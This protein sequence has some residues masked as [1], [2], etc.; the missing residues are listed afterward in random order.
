MSQQLQNAEDNWMARAWMSKVTWH[1]SGYYVLKTEDTKDVQVRLFLTEKLLSELEFSVYTQLVNATRF[2]GAKLVCLTPDAHQG[3]G[4]PVGSVLLTDADTGAIAMGPVGYDIGC[5]MLSARSSVQASMATHDRKLAFNKEV[6][7]RV[8]LGMGGTSDCSFSDKEFMDLIHGGV[9][10]MR[11]KV[12]CHIDVS[13]FERQKMLVEQGWVPPW[14][15]Q[16]NPERGKTQ[17]GSLG[18]GNHFIEL[19]SGCGPDTDPRDLSTGFL[20]VQVHTGSRGFGHGLA[21]NFFNMSKEEHPERG[22][23]IDLGFFTPDSPN[24]KNYQNAVAAAAN[25][26]MANRFIIYT[27]VAEAFRKVFKADLELVYEISHNLVQLETHP[28]FGKSWVH[29]KGAT[30]A[31]PAGHE[32]LRGMQFFET[33]HPVLIPGSNKDESFILRP[34]SGSDKSAFSVNHGAGRKL[35]RSKANSLLSQEDVN[36]QYKRAKVIVNMED[37]VPLDESSACYKPS[38]E[39][40]QAVLDAGL[41]KVETRLWPL[42]SLKGT[43]SSGKHAKIARKNQAMQRDLERS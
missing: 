41:A 20:Y 21:T 8:S 36:E 39:V 23:D 12:R 17:L 34:L 33:G 19:Q 42:A 24:Y 35:S 2:P 38:S 1:D 29:R 37:D 22:K 40:I 10:T 28:T 7:E 6:M 30:R 11:S 4:V 32:A 25:Y 15:G 14:G 9:E 43:E 3:Y 27:K 31:F 16:G 26:A 18:G 5:G 13:R